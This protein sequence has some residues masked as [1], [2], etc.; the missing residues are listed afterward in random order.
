MFP[1]WIEPLFALIALVG[2]IGFAFRQG[3]KVKPDKD[4]PDNWQS[5]TGGESASEGSQHGLDA[6]S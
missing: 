1:N 6:H 5:Y 3:T 2:F 4:N